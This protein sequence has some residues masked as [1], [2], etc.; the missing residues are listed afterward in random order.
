MQKQDDSKLNYIVIDKPYSEVLFYRKRWFI[1]ITL[2]LFSPLT[3][4]IVLTGEIYGQQKGQTIQFKE[5]QR[6]VIGLVA[7]V[8]IVLA[9]FRSIS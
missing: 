5:Q 1:V 3:L 8:F 2:L 6:V 9:I 7:C 4:L